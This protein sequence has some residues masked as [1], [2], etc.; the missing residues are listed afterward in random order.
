VS[1]R[2][3]SEAWSE[4]PAPAKLNLF[5]HV[6][7]RR[8]DG[9]HTLQSVFQLLDWGDTIHFRVRSD[10]EIHRVGT[11]SDVS[12]ADDLTLRAARLLKTASVVS[13][14]ADIRVDKRIP[15]G[16]GMGG[17][18]SDAATA[19]VALNQLWNCG[20]GLAELADLGL[21]LGTDVPVFVHGRSAFAEGIG[22]QLTPVDLPERTFVCVDPGVSV[23]THALFQSDELTRDSAPLTIAGFVSGAKTHN[24]FEP[25][26]R[27]RYPAVARAQDWLARSGD[28]RLTGT[29][30]VVFAAVPSDQARDIAAGCPPAM[31]AW[32]VRGVNVSPLLARGRDG[33][34]TAV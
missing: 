3:S 25:V 6:T 11:H 2:E 10:G 17:G 31:R 32:V 12:E 28:A 27:A 18:S 13:A 8:E 26:V 14:G 1:E 20:L 22:E 29:G 34:E 21:Q 4:W 24:A 9:Y 30:G 19:L 5:L 16:G 23:S 33:I 7:G 15:A